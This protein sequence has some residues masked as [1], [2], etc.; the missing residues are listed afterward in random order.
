MNLNEKIVEI[1]KQ[2]PEGEP[3]FDALDAM[4]RGDQDILDSFMHFVN[5]K[6]YPDN[7]RY[8][9][10]L[11]G[12]FGNAIFSAFG[13]DLYQ[14]Y[15][16]VIL[17]TGGIRKGEV[18]VIFKDT[19]PVKD[20]IFLDDSFYS[21]TTMK[22]IA[23][24]LGAL[25]GRIVKTFV[26]YDGSKTKRNDVFSMYRYFDKYPLDLGSEIPTFEDI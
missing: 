17:V 4:I 20:Y 16:D 6:V 22:A 24:K 3:F 25:S 12:N 18:P 1:L 23:S 9:I 15:G 26:I 13:L 8:G 21:G 10:I 5:N 7:K 2:H 11:S 19:L 14:I